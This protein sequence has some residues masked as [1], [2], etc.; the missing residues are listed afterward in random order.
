MAENKRGGANRGQGR[1]P[2]FDEETKM[3]CFRVPISKEAEIKKIVYD[4]LGEY[5]KP[6]NN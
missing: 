2:K 6:A 1:K 4:K 5:K 3:I